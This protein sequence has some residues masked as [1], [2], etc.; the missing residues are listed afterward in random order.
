[1]KLPILL[2]IGPLDRTRVR[3]FIADARA[4]YGDCIKPLPPSR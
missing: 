2:R 4:H 3:S 1:M